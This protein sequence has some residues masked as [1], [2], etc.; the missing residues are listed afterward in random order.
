MQFFVLTLTAVVVLTIIGIVVDKHLSKK[1]KTQSLREFLEEDSTEEVDEHLTDLHLHP[2]YSPKNIQKE[3]TLMGPMVMSVVIEDEERSKKLSYN[4]RIAL[5]L[6]ETQGMVVA[7]DYCN[8]C[9]SVQ[10]RDTVLGYI[11]INQLTK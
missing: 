8:S 9:L 5:G 7:L 3:D 10:E 11:K 2:A 6:F 1:H 4:Q